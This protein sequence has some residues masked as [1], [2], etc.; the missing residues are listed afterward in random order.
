[1][2]APVLAQELKQT[3]LEIQ[4]GVKR[5]DAFHRLSN[6]T[7][8][9]DLRDA[10]GDDHPDRAVRHQRVARAARPF[11]RPCGPNACSAPR[12]RRRWCRSR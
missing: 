10:V 3:L 12:R 6:R 8:V 11:A 7:G 5:A 2:V 1:M 9:E 4:A